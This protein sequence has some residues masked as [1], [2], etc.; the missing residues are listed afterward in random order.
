[1]SA[2]SLETPKFMMIGKVGS[3]GLAHGWNKTVC[4]LFSCL[5]NIW[6]HSCESSDC[7][8]YS[9]ITVYLAM[10]SCFIRFVSRLNAPS[11]RLGRFFRSIC[12]MTVRI[13]TKFHLQ[14]AKPQKPTFSPSKSDFQ[15]IHFISFWTV[16]D[17]RKVPTDQLYKFKFGK[18]FDDVII[19]LQR[20]V[21]AKLENPPLYAFRKSL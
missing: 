6:S 16:W 17:T 19:V 14:V 15:S 9:Q 10:L 7:F 13:P 3:V 11:K 18:V 20:S 8:L 1:M 21:A 12:Q 5:A 2:K 4:F